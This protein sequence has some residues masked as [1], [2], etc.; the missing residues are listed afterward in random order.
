MRLYLETQRPNGNK[1][2]WVVGFPGPITFTGIKKVKL[3][4]IAPD[5]LSAI[6]ATI[7]GAEVTVG[8]G[9]HLLSQ[10]ASSVSSALS[11]V[12]PLTSY[13]SIVKYVA[14]SNEPNAVYNAD[15]LTNLVLPALRNV[16]QALAQLNLP[17]KVTIPFSMSIMSLSYPPSAGQLQASILPQL[18]ALL[19]VNISIVISPLACLPYL[20]FRNS[21]IIFPFL[22]VQQVL[23]DDG[24]QVHIN[25]YPYKAYRQ[26]TA[27]ITLNYALGKA[28][29]TLIQDGSLTYTSLFDAMYDASRAA[30]DR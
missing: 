15:Q 23:V 14:V 5:T 10:A 30:L 11:I 1:L 2:Y 13:A 9:N 12:Q 22:S 18:K 4:D 25:M 17:I 8:I 21:H 27:Q 20:V 16:R 7:P 29:F 6:Q 3:Y 24:S 19:Q 28:P 26:N